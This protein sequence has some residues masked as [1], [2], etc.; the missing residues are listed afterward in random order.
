[1]REIKDVIDFIKEG[2][3]K[4]LPLIGIPDQ[5]PTLEDRLHELIAQEEVPDDKAACV[6]LY[7]EYP[8]DSFSALKYRLVQR[9]YNHL[10]FIDLENI[11]RLHHQEE[12]KAADYYLKAVIL[13]KLKHYTEASEFFYK[14]YRIAEKLDLTELRVINLRYLLNNALTLRQVKE[15]EE[16]E[17]QLAKYEKILMDEME[18]HRLHSKIE[19]QLTMP[20]TKQRTV[21][22]NIKKSLGRIE[23]LLKK[24][25]SHSIFESYYGLN[26]RLFELTARYDKLIEL[27]EEAEERWRKGKINEKQFD[28]EKNKILAIQSHI[29]S[30]EVRKGV[31]LAEKYLPYFKEGDENWFIFSY[32]MVI[33]E[34]HDLNFIKAYRVLENATRHKSFNKQSQELLEKYALLQG[35]MDIVTRQQPTEEMFENFK[36][37]PEEEMEVRID[38]NL[39]YYI[40]FLQEKDTK[41]LEVLAEKLTNYST[42]HLRIKE[43]K[44]LK[45]IINLLTCIPKYKYN[46]AL[47]KD[48]SRYLYNNLLEQPINEEEKA[49]VEVIPYE[50]IWEWALDLLKSDYKEKRPPR[51]KKVKKMKA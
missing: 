44:R 40:F 36:H 5:T 20:L 35:Y 29:K 15:F 45:N 8:N 1:M 51:K 18:A 50:V 19:M 16:Y 6:V 22:S 14:S 21:V 37:L 34:N 26:K 11:D 43:N 12:I 13:Q 2:T 33:L 10:Y 48:R 4:R 41:N 27:T 42:K 7:G 39:L 47:V 49:E 38:I 32:N 46:W 23:E 3:N 31:K 24:S 9:L 28:H 30:N 17:K 25:Q